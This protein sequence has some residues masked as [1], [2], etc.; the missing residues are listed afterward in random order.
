M[1]P[2]IAPQK[3]IFLSV[4]VVLSV[5]AISTYL[6]TTAPWMGIVL[7][8]GPQCEGLCVVEVD[9]KG[10]S[11]GVLAAGDRL[12]ALA[13]SDML[14]QSDDLIEE[15][16]AYSLY[17][18]YNAFFARQDKLYSALSQPRVV[19]QLDDGRVEQVIPYPSR[20]IS[21]LPLLFW[22]Q[23]ICG[24]MVFLAGMGI[25][26][27][28][29]REQVTFFYALTGFGLMLASSSAAIYST[30]ELAMAGELFYRLSLINQFG[31]L[32]FAGPFISILWYYP[33]RLH[34]FPLGPVV[35]GCYMLSWLLNLFQVYDSLDVAMRY[36]IFIGLLINLTLATI[37]WRLSTN[38]PLQRA[39]LKWFLLAWLSGTTLYIGLYTVPL[40]LN[41]DT[42]I[43]QSMGWGVLVTVYLGIA[44]GIT[45]FRLFNLDRWVLTGWFWFLGGVGVIIIDVALISLLEIHDHLSLAIAVGF[46]GWIYFP[47][48]Q[49]LWSR[50]SPNSK[51]TDYRE[52][53]P[54][55]LSTLLSSRL[56]NL[57][58]EWQ[59]LLNRLYLPLNIEPVEQAPDTVQLQ[60]EGIALTIPAFG[61]ING[62]QLSYADRGSRLFNNDDR[63]FADAI[64]QLFSHIQEFR[65]AFTKGVH[66]ERRRL[67][68]DLH[69][70]VG[71]RLLSLVYSASNEH[72]EELAR[73]TLGEL[74]AVIQDLESKHHLLAS[75]M[76]ELR[77]ETAERCQHRGITLQWNLSDNIR[78]VL[79]EPREHTNLK[80]ILREAVSNALRHSDASNLKVDVQK[81]AMQLIITVSN[82]NVHFDPN[83]PHQPGR[84]MRNI[85]ARAVELGGSADW[86]M[87][88]E[89]LLGGYTVR[90][91]IPLQ[92]GVLAD[93]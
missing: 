15:P 84:G 58:E 72:Q 62:L 64:F 83:H 33:Q 73:D 76:S 25:L 13:D 3:I 2:I 36:P 87:G 86:Q 17:R 69:D 67:A 55:L 71:A 26:A 49:H 51:N 60:A 32:L 6:A 65:D 24:A 29:P 30:R 22:Y 53:L 23:L 43:S 41:F 90:I 37:Q 12:K 8:G 57:Q 59:Q 74:R 56:H 79:L 16:D 85:R 63:R 46:A 28:R 68:R 70:D 35:I 81:E 18:D 21:A 1:K 20:P 78:D 75:T 61:D 34:P 88:K 91:E 9:D 42:I 89:S 27:F 52:L 14:L 80:R 7:G 54:S 11:A 45:R 66:E 47:L 77:M 19:L 38:R 10:P 92:G 50:F 31:S 93:E 82:D 48:R 40:V 44:M 5:F 39:I 4:L